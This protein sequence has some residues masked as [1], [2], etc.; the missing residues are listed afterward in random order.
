MVLILIRLRESV[1]LVAVAGSRSLNNVNSHC[2]EIDENDTCIG[3]LLLLSTPMDAFG[4][5][6]TTPATPLKVE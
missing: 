2:V 5:K 6:Q 3:T 1:K 4:S